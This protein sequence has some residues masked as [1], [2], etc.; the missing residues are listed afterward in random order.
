MAEIGPLFAEVEIT[1]N[2]YG[3]DH[4]TLYVDIGTLSGSV[5]AKLR[6]LRAAPLE[7]RI[8]RDT[9]LI[10]E[11]PVVGGNK[12]GQILTL[13]CFDPS[14]HLDYMLVTTD[15]TFTA[16]DQFTIAKTLVD[17]WQA[18]DYGDYG[19][20]TSGIGTSGQDRTLELT[21]T[22]EM[23]SVG[24]IIRDLGEADNGFDQSIDYDSRAL[25]LTTV[26]GSDLSGDVFLERG[27]GSDD[28]GFTVSPGN[29]ASD[30]YMTGVSSTAVPITAV[31][32]NTT[33]RSTFGRVGLGSTVDQVSEQ[34]LL[35][36]LA[37]GAV[38]ARA[39]P[40]FQPSS[41]LVP[42]SGARVDDFNVGDTVSY[43]F[44]AGL[45]QQTG[46]YRVTRRQISVKNNGTER[47]SVE[48]E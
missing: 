46:S 26:R 25:V 19:I 18:L 2:L 48:F 38:D 11:G 28:V 39:E 45:G 16:T 22:T 8:Y 44:D 10:F 20:D 32:T 43:A 7:V 5:K 14:S 29:I 31:K 27:I 23:P 15:K 42:V 1:E 37:Q 6:N 3:P 36:D 21:G 33:L 12:T 9:V 24:E 35:D 40:Y 30:V 34:A 13:T 41:G 4:V 17:D 47:I